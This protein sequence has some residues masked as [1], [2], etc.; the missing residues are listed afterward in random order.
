M[1]R[2]SNQSPRHFLDLFDVSTQDLR[3]ILDASIAM[4]KQRK[5]GNTN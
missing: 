1:T 4:K 5:A 3:T 2:P